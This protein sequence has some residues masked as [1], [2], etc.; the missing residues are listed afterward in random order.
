MPNVETLTRSFGEGPR[1]ALAIHCSP[2]HSGSVTGLMGALSDQLTAIAYD[3]PSHGKSSDWDGTGDLHDVATNMGRALLTEPM[4]LIGHSFGATV[5]M[6]LG[7][8]HPEL[9]RSLTMIEPVYFAHAV[10]D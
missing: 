7:M 9:V 10:A 4:D 3:L 2:A 5:A 6:R 1:R 8:E